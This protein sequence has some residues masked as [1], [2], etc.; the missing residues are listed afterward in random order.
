MPELAPVF[1][2]AD[3][4][5]LVVSPECETGI[6]RKSSGC[7][8][9]DNRMGS[10]LRTVIHIRPGVYDDGQIVLP[11]T[12][13]NVTFEG[14]DSVKTVLRYH[15]NVRGAGSDGAAGRSR[16]T[17][18][19]IEADN[20]SCGRKF[21]SKMYQ[22]IMGRAMALRVDGDRA[23]FKRLPD[24]GVAGHA[25]DQQWADVFSRIVFVSGRV[26]FIYGSATGD[27]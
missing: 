1:I 16:G 12:K 15:W 5:Y 3:R 7:D 26:D 22:G 20:F 9:C 8:W 11:A 4:R 14:E 27:F 23:V 19:V 18:V 17:G 2:H 24:D 6:F 25:A 13:A 21:V 10:A